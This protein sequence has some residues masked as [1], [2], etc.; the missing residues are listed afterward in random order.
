MEYSNKRD[1]HN[2]YLD[3]TENA[4]EEVKKQILKVTSDDKSYDPNSLLEIYL[5]LY[6]Y[7]DKKKPILEFLENQQLVK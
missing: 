5:W 2:L 6:I 4:Y 1:I 3:H 7:G